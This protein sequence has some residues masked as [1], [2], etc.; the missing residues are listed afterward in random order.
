[1]G[2]VDG[3]DGV[4]AYVEGGMGSVSQA[5]ANSARSHGA[6]IFTGKVCL[7]LMSV[8][9]LGLR[10]RICIFS[11]SLGLDLSCRVVNDLGFGL[12]VNLW[13]KAGKQV[14]LFIRCNDKNITI[15]RPVLMSVLCT[16]HHLM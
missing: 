16:L 6:S 2:G 5:I 12:K 14:R 7:S 15:R 8:V 1:M 11:C 4:W 13:K 9:R 10:E 3:L